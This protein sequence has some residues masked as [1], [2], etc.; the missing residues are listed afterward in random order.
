MPWHIGSVLTWCVA[1]FFIVVTLF[2]WVPTYFLARKKGFM[3]F[4]SVVLPKLE[5]TELSKIPSGDTKSAAL[6]VAEKSADLST[7][8]KNAG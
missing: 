2:L 6:T 7:V 3:E 4:D 8:E 1:G 5:F